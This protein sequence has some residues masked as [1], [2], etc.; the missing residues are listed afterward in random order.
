M[1]GTRTTSAE[2]LGHEFHYCSVLAN[3]DAPFAAITDATG[4]PASDP[5]ARR[6][7]V[8][9]TFFHVIDHAS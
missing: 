2:L 8:T 9:G 3:P 5:G 4:A 6:G 1:R 7:S